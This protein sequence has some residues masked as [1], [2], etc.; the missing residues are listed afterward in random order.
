MTTPRRITATAIGGLLL[1]GAAGCG[2][3][4]ATHDVESTG[5]TVEPLGAEASGG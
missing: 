4:E 3:G 5:T 2:G 1:L